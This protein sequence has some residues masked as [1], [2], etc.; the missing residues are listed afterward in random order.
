[1]RKLFRGVTDQSAPWGWRGSAERPE[2]SI[3]C[4]R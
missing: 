4:V 3:Q 1:V 2:R